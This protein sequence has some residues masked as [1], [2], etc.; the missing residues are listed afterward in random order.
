MWKKIFQDITFE[1]RKQEPG[2]ESQTISIVKNI[3]DDLPDTLT[4][5]LVR[6]TLSSIPRGVIFVPVFDEFDRIKSPDASNLMA[7]TIKALSDFGVDATILIIGV[8]DSIDELIEE[9]HSIERT[10]IQIPMQRMSNAEV[11]TIIENG[12]NALSLEIDDMEKKTIVD[13]SQGLPYITHLLSLHSAK[14]AIKRESKII[15][16][17]DIKEGIRISLSDWQQSIKS[18]YYQATRSPQPGNIFR[19]VILACAF[20]E[21]DDLGYFSAASVRAPLNTI[22]P[23]RS[24]D[25]PN[26]ARHLKLLSGPDRGG[27]FDRV[28]EKRRLRYRFISPLMRP[29]IVMRGIDD[30]IISRDQLSELAGDQLTPSVSVGL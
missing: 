19:E 27:L 7:D 17:E 23:D 6:R 14:S 20:A 18:A 24:Y 2:F 1:K 15:Q 22:V 12:L 21:T 25:I 11:T 10:L 16:R 8:A 13:L 3:A 4:P 28:G 29:Y 5:D 26:Y 9:H 30:Q